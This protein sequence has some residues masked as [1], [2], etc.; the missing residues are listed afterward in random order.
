MSYQRA[1]SGLGDRGPSDEELER[2][3]RALGGLRFGSVTLV[4]QD[5]VIVQIDRTEKTRVRDRNPSIRNGE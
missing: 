4:V 5:G 2:I 3:V 1:E